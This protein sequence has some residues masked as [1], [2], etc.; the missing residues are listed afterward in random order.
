LVVSGRGVDAART[1]AAFWAAR[2]MAIAVVGVAVPTGLEE[3]P[4]VIVQGD[5]QLVAAALSAARRE[6]APAIKGRTATVSDGSLG[7]A[8]LR[9]LSGAGYASVDSTAEPWRQAA[10]AVGATWIVSL[11]LLAQGGTNGGDPVGTAVPL[12]R[13]APSPWGQALRPLSPRRRA[14]L[15]QLEQAVGAATGAAARCA[16]A[17][18]LGPAP[19]A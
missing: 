16:I 7:E 14:A 5:E 18:V 4:R 15:R 10:V 6:G 11:G 1:A 8:A 3:P 9:S 17:A 2:A 12:G 19:S 13:S